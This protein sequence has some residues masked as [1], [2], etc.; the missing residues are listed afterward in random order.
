[1]RPKGVLRKH[2][3]FFLLRKFTW[4]YSYDQNSVYWYCWFIHSNLA[5][6]KDS[7]FARNSYLTLKIFFMHGKHLSLLQDTPLVLLTHRTCCPEQTPCN[8]IFLIP[9]GHHVR[10]QHY[11]FCGCLTRMGNCIERVVIGLLVL[12]CLYPKHF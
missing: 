9:D 10:K 3:G 7:E 12:D 1:M 4:S 11:W 2:S 8:F 6:L 5:I